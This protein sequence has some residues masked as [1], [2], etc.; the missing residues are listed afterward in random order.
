M[1]TGQQQ[2]QQQ[3]TSRRLAVLMFTD[4]IGSAELKSRLGTPAYARLLARHDELFRELL[5]E[6]PSAEVLQD[7][8]D[9]YFAA[10]GTVSE[11]VRFALRFQD[12]MHRERWDAPQPLRTRI[13]IHL[14]E[15]AHVARGGGGPP[16]VVGIAADLA[17]RVMSLACGAQILL[18]RAAFDEARQFV[19]EYPTTNGDGQPRALRW[20]AHGEYVF[21][22]APEPVQVFEVGGDGIAPLTPPR[23]REKARRS[24]IGEKKEEILGWRPAIG[25]PVPQS[26]TW[27]L[28]R[29]LGEGTFG[30]VWLARHHKLKQQRVFK[31]C[32]D[33]ERLESFKRELTLFRLLRDAL[34]DRRDI[35]RLFDVYLDH[36]PYFIES[37]FAA[38]GNLIDWANARGGLPGIPLATRLELVAQVCDAVGAAH[39]VGVLHKDI[40]PTNILIHTEPADGTPRAQISDFGIGL[41]TDRGQLAARHIT[42]VGFTV[43]PGMDSSRSSGTRI[44]APP[45]SLAGRPF[46]VQG[47][48]Y[49]LGVLLYQMTIADTDRP[50][51]LGWERDVADELLREDIGAC[52]DGD[53]QRRV[54]SASD[55]ATRLRRLEDRRRQRRHDRELREWSERRRRMLRVASVVAAGL[56][57]MTSLA[58]FAY[59]RE[60]GKNKIER[61]LRV[62]A[63]ES[64]HAAKLS[65]A[66]SAVNEGFARHL[67]GQGQPSREA[68]SRAR[69]A[70]RQLGVSPLPAEVVL[71]RSFREFDAPIQT[72]DARSKD[73]MSVAWLSDNVRAVSAGGEGGEVCLWDAQTGRLLRTFQENQPFVGAVAVSRDGKRLLSAG[74]DQ[75]SR[76]W[77]VETGNLLQELLEPPGEVRG[78]AFSPDGRLAVSGSY[79][80]STPTVRIWN[81][82]DKSKKREIPTPTGAPFSAVAFSPDGRQLLATTYGNGD[83][84]IW[85]VEAEDRPP[86]R[87][88]KPSKQHILCAAFS[89]DGRHVIS[90]GHDGLLRLSDTSTGAVAPP[91]KGH[92]APV[93][94]V[95]FTGGGGADGARVLSCSMDDTLKWWD[96][97]S[98]EPLRTL[99]G[100]TGGVR[101]ISVSADGNR[102]ISASTDGTLRI[103]NL[104]AGSE[105]PSVQDV[106]SVTS[107]TCSADGLMLVCGN[108]TGTVTLRDLATLRVLRTVSVGDQPIDH[109]ALL[110]DGKRLFAADGAG[111]AKLWDVTG[112]PESRTYERRMEPGDI[113]PF[114]GSGWRYTRV[115]PNGSAAISARGGH[116]DVW[117]LE[118]GEVLRSLG[119]VKG[120]ITCLTIS[121]DGKHALSGT[122][123]GQ[124]HYWD[125]SVVQPVFAKDPPRSGALDVVAFAPDGKRAL[126]G[127]HDMT[128]RAWDLS[129]PLREGRP[130]PG[131]TATVQGVGFGRDGQTIFSA[132]DD[133]TLRLFDMETGRELELGVTFQ[134]TPLGL[135]VIPPGDAVAVAAGRTIRV[136]DMSRAARHLDEQAHLVSARSALQASQGRDAAALATLGRW[137]AFRG[138]DD[139]AVEMLEGA[140]AAGD[141]DVSSL[142]LA[143]CYWQ[144]DRTADASREFRKALDRNEAP[145][146]YVKLCLA[147]VEGSPTTRPTTAPATRQTT[148][149]NAR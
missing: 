117:S 31:F 135:A 84:F 27:V 22:G 113:P 101:G 95:A 26:P 108:R 25:L 116:I 66:D 46:T 122:H 8:G 128:V 118:T 99:A 145:A 129:S 73:L 63:E 3:D 77:D 120:D 18:T 86:V 106:T 70:Y 68:L 91:F 47:D 72:F 85:D 37:E 141:A 75:P 87:L 148:I 119:P 11:A 98:G 139:W 96:V 55:M 38:E 24:T 92:T 134:A 76:L 140:R 50:L 12:A 36:P 82:A 78:I 53:P 5:A 126:S 112:G 16:K 28:E 17:A 41:L 58:V 93:R 34:G 144:L 20:M 137:Y 71:H 62:R 9:G 43:M 127:G 138:M 65:A 123:N 59:V 142:T 45:E 147:A 110:A 97:G 131:H 39:S 130:Y 109:A 74:K 149:A 103:W 30:E 14:G 111:L 42:E 57:V 48:I 132:G 125:L 51:A 4:V 19:S 60:K 94:G 67:A 114:R 124:L 44:Y 143:R 121:P 13:G 107:L 21:Q 32:F 104:R 64:E 136:Y 33:A 88:D 105:V 133:R 80:A 56:C 115:A 35:A 7:T 89:P 81:L 79:R 146:A 40:K 29:K 52:V 1:S 61:E 83:V 49:A 54:N 10:F 102:G 69:D 15:L 100:H 90:G 23:D 6:C 2:Q